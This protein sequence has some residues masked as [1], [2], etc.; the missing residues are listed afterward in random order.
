MRFEI[1]LTDEAVAD[2]KAL[3][4]L[5][6]VAVKDAME[7]HL[8]HEPEK[9]SRSRIKRLRELSKPQFRLRVEDIRVFYDVEK[10]TVTVHAIVLKSEAASWLAQFGESK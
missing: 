5:W 8:R 9:V 6:R 10:S 4:A 1:E 3:K 7:V 2:F